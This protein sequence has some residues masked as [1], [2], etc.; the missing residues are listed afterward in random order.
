M[1]VISTATNTQLD[2]VQFQGTPQNS[3]PF[4]GG[5]APPA[6][7][8][9]LTASTNTGG[10]IVSTPPGLHC[11]SNNA[12]CTEDFAPGT[13]VTLTPVALA[14]YTFTGWGGDCSG[15][16]SCAVTMNAAHTVSAT[17]A[18][19][20]GTQTYNL[21]ITA[22]N[23]GIVQGTNVCTTSPACPLGGIFL[24]TTAV[25]Y[26]AGA[27]ANL[28]AFPMM[29][30]AFAGWSGDCSGVQRCFVTMNS[31]HAVTANFVAGT[32]PT[33]ATV[34]PQAGYWWNPAEAGRG[35]VIEFN[36]TN[37]FMAAFL[38]DQ[39]GRSTWYGAGPAPLTGATF[40][41]PLSA[42]QGG[43]TLTG[44]YVLPTPGTSP[45]Q[46][47]I[48]FSDAAN[49]T[50]T[51]PGGPIP[52]TRFPFEPNGLSSPPTPAQPQ[53]GWWYNPNE[54]GRGYSI[55]VQGNFAFIAAYMY[56]NSGNPVWYDSGPVALTGN[57]VYQGTWT[58][59]TG[60]QTLTGP[61]Q[62]PPTGSSGAGNLT[63]QFSSPTTGQLTLPTGIQIPIQ[64]FTF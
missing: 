55:E 24:E 61:Y 42:Y 4:V 56:D 28:T 33:A 48:T 2:S 7:N 13:T 45:G 38:Y 46:I 31:A 39:S 53:T 10:A 29:G 14:G 21:S 5:A 50:L 37:I 64:R 57:N 1:L 25:T 11:S 62:G 8:F 3:G 6:A 19:S 20:S 51:W 16:G 30:Y 15:A 47:T 12:A 60:G 58:S 63:I 23:G 52:I 36:G 59:N 32:S 49:G 9:L 27:T 17:F 22:T 41:A 26:Q 34:F 43:Q 40:T 18:A 54:P 35:Y 44:T